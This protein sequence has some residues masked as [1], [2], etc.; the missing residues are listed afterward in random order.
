QELSIAPAGTIFP[1]IFGMVAL[2][3]ATSR[4]AA[5][6]LR[7]DEPT[8]SFGETRVEILFSLGG[9]LILFFLGFFPNLYLQNILALFQ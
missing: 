4:I 8:W 1:V 9:I 6:M 3:F 5:S 2:L 7:S